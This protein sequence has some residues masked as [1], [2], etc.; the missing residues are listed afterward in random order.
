MKLEAA[1]VSAEVTHTVEYRGDGGRSY[2]PTWS[3]KWLWRSA[4]NEFPNIE[5]MNLSSMLSV[6]EDCEVATALQ[7]IST[8]LDRHEGLRTRFSVGECRDLGQFVV[9]DGCLSVTEYQVEDLAPDAAAHSVLADMCRQAFSSS[10]I[11]FRAALITGDGKLKFIAICVFHMAADRWSLRKITGD[12][13]ILLASSPDQAR[14][15]LSPPLPALS[16]RAMFEQSPSGRSHSMNSLAFWEKQIE[17]FPQ[18]TSQRS[19]MISDPPDFRDIVMRSTAVS[20]AVY[21]LAEK[22]RVSVPAV[23]TAA[24]ASILCDALE[25]PDIGILQLCH[26]RLRA[27]TDFVSGPLIQD[28]P[29]LVQPVASSFPETCKDIRAQCM[30]GS[31]HGQYDPE[32]LSTAMNNIRERQ[33]F[34][35]D[36]SY[37]INITAEKLDPKLPPLTSPNAAELR[38]LNST[39]TETEDEAETG[40]VNMIPGLR[41]RCA[42]ANFYLVGQLDPQ[43]A[44]LVLQINTRMFSL[45]DGKRFLADLEK[46]MI[47]EFLSQYE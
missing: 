21:L 38:Q 8:L 46:L 36:L 40:R 13:K 24:T 11:S 5:F 42:T 47:S 44:Q 43:H 37:A 34:Y 26:N 18:V 6:A 39:T 25:I 16:V 41:T 32:G 4:I 2:P 29:I 20:S 14:S 30:T 28:F 19:E 27:D 22:M 12:L 45:A 35:P 31:L 3:Q 33:G 9:D 7:A 15:S 10:E 23:L 1:G 17:F